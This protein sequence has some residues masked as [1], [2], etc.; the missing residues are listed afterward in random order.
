[1]KAWTELLSNDTVFLNPEFDMNN[2]LN[3]MA[4]GIKHW[5]NIT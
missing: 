1:M 5:K 3:I 2:T 4:E